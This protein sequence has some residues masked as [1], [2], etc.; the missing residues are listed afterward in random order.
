MVG[1]KVVKVKN[2]CYIE[3]LLII[4][5]EYYYKNKARSLGNLTSGISK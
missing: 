2:R 5:K 3:L 4:V 1:S